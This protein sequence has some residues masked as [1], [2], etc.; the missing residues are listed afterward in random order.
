L[1]KFRG[2]IRIIKIDLKALFLKQ[3]KAGQKVIAQKNS[4][5]KQAVSKKI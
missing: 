5:G 1:C 3:E 4:T 2:K